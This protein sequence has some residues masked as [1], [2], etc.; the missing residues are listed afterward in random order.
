VSFGEA[1]RIEL[2]GGTLQVRVD[3]ADLA[4]TVKGPARHVFSGTLF[5]A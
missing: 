2:P 1:A 4:V 3:A 5:S